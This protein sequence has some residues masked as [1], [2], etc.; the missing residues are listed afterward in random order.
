MTGGRKAT[1]LEM[2][3]QPGRHEGTI[4]Q[5][6]LSLIKDRP[7]FLFVN[8]GQKLVMKLSSKFFHVFCYAYL[9]IS[10]IPGLIGIYGCSCLVDNHYKTEIKQKRVICDDELQTI[11]DEET[12][13]EKNV[14]PK[15]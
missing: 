7:A 11:S 3:R 14:D 15:N 10:I 2:Q 1:G 6:G 4:S 9:L 8:K 12:T 5:A 13:Q